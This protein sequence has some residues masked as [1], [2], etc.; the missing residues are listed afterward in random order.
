[1][2]SKNKNYYKSKNQSKSDLFIKSKISLNQLKQKIEN[3]PSII[4]SINEKG[5]TLLSFSLNKSLNEVYDLILNYPLLNLKYK[6]KEGN[7]YLH[8]AVINQNEKVVNLLIK[9]GINLNMQNKFGNTA[10]HL[11]Y[12]YGN[13]III[14]M[15]IN[16]GINTLIRNK[17]NKIAKEKKKIRINKKIRKNKSNHFNRCDKNNLIDLKENILKPT[18]KYGNGNIKNINNIEKKDNINNN[19]IDLQLYSKYKKNYPYFQNEKNKKYNESVIDKTFNFDTNINDENN[20]NP[21]LFKEYKGQK[22][23][24]NGDSLIKK[25]NNILNNISKETKFLTDTKEKSNNFEDTSSFVASQSSESKIISKIEK[26]KNNKKF[27]EFKSKYLIYDRKNINDKKIKENTL[28]N[29][30]KSYINLNNIKSDKWKTIQDKYYPKNN[31]EKYTSDNILKY[32]IPTNQNNM[33]QNNKSKSKKQLFSNK[34]TNKTICLREIKSQNSFISKINRKKSLLDKYLKSEN[35]S[36]RINHIL[37][38]RNINRTKNKDFLALQGMNKGNNNQESQPIYIK[39]EKNKSISKNIINDNED[40]NGLTMKSSKLLKNF[41]SQINMEKYI[42]IF[43]F[44]GFD[45]INLILEQS[46]NGIS[47]IQDS[48]LKEA[49]I[50]IPGDRAKIL[51]RI[52]EISNNFNFPVPKEV[53]YSIENNKTIENDK[54]IQK[55]KHWLKSIKVDNYITNFINCGYY[56]LELLMV[57]MASSNPINNEILK[58]ELGIEK[59][60]YRSRIINKLKEDSRRYIGELEINML[61][62]NNEEEKKNN[63]QCIIY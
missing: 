13:N 6:D 5:E 47:S 17:E 21:L 24:E 30:C 32:K 22:I 46:R 35:E 9:K 36:I 25:D 23:I 48:E 60:G 4:N 27:N 12:E 28:G 29:N 41:L 34:K 44:N 53:Y 15:L 55:I 10:L 50:K 16:N 54:N 57:Q 43:A 7:S 39:L 31:K 62:I 3:D 26:D 52:Q 33:F 1:M 51:I 20:I 40:E 56:S 58:E 2:D 37:K 42:T 18:R 45:D 59:I 14:S 49:G 19:M 11:A 61:V 8:L 38:K 63:C